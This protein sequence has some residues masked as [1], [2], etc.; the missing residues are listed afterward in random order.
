MIICIVMIRNRWRQVV[1]TGSFGRSRTLLSS[2]ISCQQ[3]LFQ[4]PTLNGSVFFRR[5][6][7]LRLRFTQLSEEITQLTGRT[8]I[9]QKQRTNFE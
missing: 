5:K 3:L 2:A 6:D 4:Q 9:F 7:T 1:R 8:L